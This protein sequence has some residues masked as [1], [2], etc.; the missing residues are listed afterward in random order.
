[1]ARFGG[2][3]FAVILT[4]INGR[5]DAALVAEKIIDMLGAP[6]HLRDCDRPVH[7][8]VSI[9]IAVFPAD[10]GDLEKLLKMA[11][12]AMYNAKQVGNRFQFTAGSRTHDTAS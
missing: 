2:D 5:G 12:T 4:H 8:G 3:E 9:G 10:A 1:M 6:F 7:I 11:D